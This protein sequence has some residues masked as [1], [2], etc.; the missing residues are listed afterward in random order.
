MRWVMHVASIGEINNAQEILDRKRDGRGL[1]GILGHKLENN[2]RIDI[3]GKVCR[4]VLFFLGR[5]MNFRVSYQAE[6]F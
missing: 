4:L 5:E 3:S 6:N 1:L 2:I